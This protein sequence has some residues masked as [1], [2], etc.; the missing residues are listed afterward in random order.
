MSFIENYMLYNS[1]NEANKTYHRWSAL[2][3]LSSIISRR[4]WIDM[5]YFRIYP[6]LYI[7]LLGPPGNKKTTAMTVAKSLIRQLG[8]AIP[9]SA[10]CQ[11]KESLVKE[12][13][14]YERT[15]DFPG[16]V[17]PYKY[18]PMSIFVT[19]LSQF[20]GVDPARMIDLLTTIYDQDFYDLKTKNKGCQ[21]IVGPYLTLLAC[22]TPEWITN[23]LKSDVITGGFSR[24]AL[25]VLEYDDSDIRVPFPEI[26]PVMKAAWDN[27][28]TYAHVLF[29]I[30]GEFKWDPPAKE[31]Y[32]KWYEKRTISSDPL[33]RWFDAT[34]YIQAL[35]IAML[36]SLSESTDMVIRL[37][38]L[39]QAFALLEVLKVN[40]PKVFQGIGRN[41]LN[42]VKMKVLSVLNTTGPITDRKLMAMIYSELPHGGADFDTLMRDMDK[43]GDIKRVQKATDKEP[44]PTY[45]CTIEQFN[46]ARESFAG[47]RT[48]APPFS[49]PPAVKA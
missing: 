44:R 20:I 46:M 1:G 45:I 18:T 23:Y 28:I 19:E 22:T 31:W 15:F 29:T 43:C 26:T 14:E 4:V 25:F 36:I 21:L 42:V 27:L 8:S 39:Q 40:L 11:T 17:K 47:D 24:R 37:G 6:N 2:S 10:E 34:S 49:Q 32:I 38:H 35:K 12:L 48:S 5:G 13:A 16:A 41:E 30:G 7:V 33:I 3:A 9:F